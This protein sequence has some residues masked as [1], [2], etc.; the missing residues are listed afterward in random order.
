MKR[1][2]SARLLRSPRAQ[3][4]KKAGELDV[5]PLDTKHVGLN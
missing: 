4:A 2:P 1:N 5:R 3:A